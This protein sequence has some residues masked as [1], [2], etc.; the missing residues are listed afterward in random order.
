MGPGNGNSS[1]LSAVDTACSAT[2]RRMTAGGL[3]YEM[4]GIQWEHGRIGY[5]D[6]E[7]YHWS[8]VTVDGRIFI[9]DPCMDIIMPTEDKFAHPVVDYVFSKYGRG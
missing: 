3:M 6:V 9:I 4:L 2:V 7:L 1:A 5:G 8:V